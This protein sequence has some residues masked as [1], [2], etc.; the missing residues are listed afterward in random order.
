MELGYGS[1]KLGISFSGN[2]S[3]AK[4]VVPIF[5][6]VLESKIDS[7]YS[8]EVGKSTKFVSS[9]SNLPNSPMKSSSNEKPVES[10][11]DE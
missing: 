7:R 6:K 1:V 2:K 8:S 11:N 9:I 3:K 4:E 5:N 10:I